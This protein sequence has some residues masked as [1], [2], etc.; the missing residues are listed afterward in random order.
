[1]RQPG[2]R[3]PCLAQQL[4]SPKLGWLVAWGKEMARAPLSAGVVWSCRHCHIYW[5]VGDGDHAVSRGESTKRLPALAATE[6]QRKAWKL[7]AQSSLTVPMLPR[8]LQDAAR[9]NRAGRGLAG[10][11]WWSSRLPG[12]GSCRP[13]FSLLQPESGKA[14]LA[15]LAAPVAGAHAPAAANPCCSPPMLCC[16]RCSGRCLKA[17]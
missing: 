2:A 5:G 9:S 14:A 3:L 13:E 1:M 12:A 4:R 6:G 8:S 11:V 7:E 15:A 10:A 17:T 16:Q